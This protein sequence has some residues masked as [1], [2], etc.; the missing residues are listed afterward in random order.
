MNIHHKCKFCNVDLSLQGVYYIHD[1][2]PYLFRINRSQ[3]HWWTFPIE[4]YRVFSGIDY[5]TNTEYA[6]IRNN[7]DNNYVHCN[8]ALLPTIS[9]D[10][11]KIYLEFI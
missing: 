3:F 8:C 1:D 10:E 4:N 5:E 6:S 11:L 9:I 2:C 7:Y